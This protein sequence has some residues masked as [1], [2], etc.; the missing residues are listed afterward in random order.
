M[1]WELRGLCPLA[2]PPV[3]R[4]FHTCLPAGKVYQWEDPDPRLFNHPE[5]PTPN[6]EEPLFLTQAEVYKELRLRGYD[7]GPHFHGIL[8]ASLEGGY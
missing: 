1:A 6:P 4:F 8:E 2:M 7:Y 3:F 5:S